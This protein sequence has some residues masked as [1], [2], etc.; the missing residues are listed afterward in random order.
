[1]NKRDYVRDELADIK[2][3]IADKDPDDNDT[4]WLCDHKGKWAMQ[5]P[6]SCDTAPQSWPSALVLSFRPAPRPACLY[7][8]LG[9]FRRGSAENRG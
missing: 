6:K 8:L 9:E 1:M 7:R 2:R 4:P 5:N 3:Q